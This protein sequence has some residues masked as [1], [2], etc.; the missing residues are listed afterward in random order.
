[1]FYRPMLC[2]GADPPRS[3][4]RGAG[5]CGRS[6]QVV[7]PPTGTAREGGV[8]GGRR[9]SASR[10]RIS[11]GRHGDALLRSAPGQDRRPRR[12]SRCRHRA[13]RCS[14]RS[15]GHRSRGPEE[16]GTD[17][18]RVSC[19]PCWRASL[20]ALGPTTPISPK[21]WPRAASLRREHAARSRRAPPTS[22][23]LD[24]GRSRRDDSRRARRRSRAGRRVRAGR[25][26][27][28][29]ARDSEPRGCAVASVR[30]LVE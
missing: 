16:Q 26:I 21:R 23:S 17:Q 5:L 7:R 15:D 25:A 18:P 27:R 19:G 11:R 1:M 4:H 3:L 2:R 22:R 20:F 29:A 13:S 28:G 9:R 8:A 24:R 6:R 12:R 14:A 10:N 30:A